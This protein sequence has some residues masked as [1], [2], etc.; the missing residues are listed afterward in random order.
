[1]RKVVLLTI[2]SS[3]F[4]T[5]AVA[6]TARNC[7]FLWYGK[8]AAYTPTMTYPDFMDMCLADSYKVPAAWNDSTR[9]PAGMTGKCRDG[10]WT[11]ETTRQDACITNGGIDTWYKR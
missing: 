9:P 7:S 3:L 11:T 4:A 2:A 10:T 6:D 5:A 1:M 8:R